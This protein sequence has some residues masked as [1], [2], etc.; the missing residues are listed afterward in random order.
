MTKAYNT[1]ANQLKILTV[2]DLTIDLSDDTYDYYGYQE[3][4]KSSIY[5]TLYQEKINRMNSEKAYEDIR[6]QLNSAK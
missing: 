1:N 2:D 4:E 6:Q 3:H 5:D